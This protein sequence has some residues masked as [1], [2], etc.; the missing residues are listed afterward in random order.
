MLGMWCLYVE[1]FWAR[2]WQGFHLCKIHMVVCNRTFLEHSPCFFYSFQNF[3]WWVRTPVSRQVSIRQLKLCV[4]GGGVDNSYS[5]L[6]YLATPATYIFVFMSLLW[7]TSWNHWEHIANF[8]SICLIP[9]LVKRLPWRVSLSLSFSFSAFLT[10]WKKEQPQ[11]FVC[12]YHVFTYG[13]LI[14][15]TRTSLPIGIAGGGRGN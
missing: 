5:E 9:D 4:W 6:V 3:P 7:L 10:T 13:T 12:V 11:W 15:Q 1:L 8:R 14:V 2:S